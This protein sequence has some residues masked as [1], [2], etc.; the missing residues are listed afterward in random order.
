[1]TSRFRSQS[2]VFEPNLHVN[3]LKA[4]GS[5][6]LNQGT[7]AS[8]SVLNTMSDEV[9]P[10]YFSKRRRGQF[11]PINDMDQTK[12]EITQLSEG[13]VK[14]DVYKDGILKYV[15][16]YTGPIGLHGYASFFGGTL[17]P[18][19]FAGTPSWPSSS[20]VLTEAL[21]NARTRGWDILTFL[22]EFRK[23]LQLIARFRDRTLA[24]AERIADTISSNAV[25]PLAE[26]S[27]TWLEA[28][29]GWRI[30]AYDIESINE[31]LNKLQNLRPPFL[32]GYAEDENTSSTTFDFSN[33]AKY[34][35]KYTPYYAPTA[36]QCSAS[37]MIEQSKTRKTRGGVVLELLLDDIFE[38]DPLVTGWEIIPFSFIVDWFVNVDEIIKAYSPFATENLLGAWTMEE[39]TLT[40]SCVFTP[41][42]LGNPNSGWYY[43]RT[44]GPGPF[45]FEVK[46]TTKERRSAS[47]TAELSFSINLDELKLIDLAAIFLTRVGRIFRGLTQSIR[48]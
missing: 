21:A 23:T 32:R 17:S 7:P 10:G 30:L 8:H 46:N 45:L 43:E 11:L 2:E 24:R 40:S 6:Y 16:T 9:S 36:I 1:M 22:V 4:D 41:Q 47:P 28:R 48:I 39:E 20:V 44:S 42:T 25:D 31:A 33:V 3:I 12:T 5:L 14:F 35:S 29:Y 15:P 18:P 26:F 19:S 13:E 27:A 34:L 37:Y 38:V